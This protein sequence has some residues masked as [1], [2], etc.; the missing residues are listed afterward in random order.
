MK[1]LLTLL[2]IVLALAGCA[3]R[4][5]ISEESPIKG[6]SN[7][8]NR[9]FVVAAPTYAG[10][11]VCG[12]PFLLLSMGVDSIYPGT[13]T[14]TYYEVTNAIW[15]VPASICGVITGTIFIPFSYI[16]DED[17]WVFDFKTVSNRRWSCTVDF[18]KP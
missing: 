11:L 16:C 4:S 2:F 1:R 5:Q 10:N 17:P 6:V 12:T 15:Y 13:R 9:N 14:E 8:Y 3:S 18:T 7:L